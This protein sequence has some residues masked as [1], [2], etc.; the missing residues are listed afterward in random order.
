ML[1]DHR[2]V[3]A[4]NRLLDPGDPTA[5]LPGPARARRSATGQAANG[6]EFTSDP[7]YGYPI[8]CPLVCLESRR[9]G[10]SESV[11]PLV[12]GSGCCGPEPIRTDSYPPRKLTAYEM[13]STSS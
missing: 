10:T 2:V 5:G 11:Q 13:K 8:A 7:A 4:A 12:S 1:L 6:R 9:I 3:H